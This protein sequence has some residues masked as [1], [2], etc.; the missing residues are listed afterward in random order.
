MFSRAAA[1][2]FNG[3]YSP[4]VDSRQFLFKLTFSETDCCD[5][6]VFLF[7]RYFPSRF[8]L[9]YISLGIET[10]SDF[11]EHAVFSVYSRWIIPV[12]MHNKHDD[13]PFLKRV[14]TSV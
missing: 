11:Y 8:I 5:R 7:G 10:I 13:S 6:P 9:L 14:F 1:L 4:N 2:I 3:H 12:I